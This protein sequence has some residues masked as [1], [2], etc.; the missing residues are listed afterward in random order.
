MGKRN[1]AAMAAPEQ[2]E[3]EIQAHKLAIQRLRLARKLAY[4]DRKVQ[5]LAPDPAPDGE[6]AKR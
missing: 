1:H 6:G 2:I 5:E 3:R 4:L